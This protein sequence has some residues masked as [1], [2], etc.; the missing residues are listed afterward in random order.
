[1]PGLF[2]QRQCPSVGTAASHVS[3]AI[4]GAGLCGMAETLGSAYQAVRYAGSDNGVPVLVFFAVTSPL[5]GS[6]MFAYGASKGAYEGLMS[7]FDASVNKASE[8]YLE[9]TDPHQ[10]IKSCKK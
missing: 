9:Y 1:M 6:C 4:V 5:W 3:G 10:A 7:G 8:I 2:F